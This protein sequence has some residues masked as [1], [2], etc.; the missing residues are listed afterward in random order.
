MDD[1]QREMRAGNSLRLVE[2][3]RLEDGCA[4]GTSPYPVEPGD[5]PG[6]AA[7]ELDGKTR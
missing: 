6:G 4:Y 3:P 1:R 2:G 7:A 5:A